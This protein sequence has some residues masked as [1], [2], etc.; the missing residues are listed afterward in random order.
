MFKMTDGVDLVWKEFLVWFGL[1]SLV[2]ISSKPGYLFCL[3]T[4]LCGK[5]LGEQNIWKWR[6]GMLGALQCMF[7]RIWDWGYKHTYYTKTLHKVNK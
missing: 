5:S 1:V 6:G 3:W 4:K 2:L 7:I